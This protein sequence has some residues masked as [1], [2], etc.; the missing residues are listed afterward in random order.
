MDILRILYVKVYTLDS[1]SQNALS[2]IRQKV[3]RKRAGSGRRTSKDDDETGRDEAA[4]R[5]REPWS[6]NVLESS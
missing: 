4:E 5:E 6:T 2:G 1:P 3:Q